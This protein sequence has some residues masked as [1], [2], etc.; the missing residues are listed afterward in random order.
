MGSSFF[1]FSI[2]FII[3]YDKIKISKTSEREWRYPWS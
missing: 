3:R 1:I 2:E